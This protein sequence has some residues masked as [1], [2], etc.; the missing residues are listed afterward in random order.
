MSNGRLDTDELAVIPGGTKMGGSALIRADLLPGLVALQAA[1]RKRWGVPLRPTSAGDG[2][3]SYEVQRRTFLARYVPART[4]EGPFSDVR[5]WAG[6]RYVRISSAGSAAVPGT[7][8]HGDAVAVDFADVGP[9]GGERWRWLMDHAPRFGWTNPPWARD[10][11]P[12]NGSIE[13]WHWESVAVPVSQYLAYLDANGIEVPGL[14]A[15][16]SLAPVPQEDAMF[17]IS[18]PGRGSALVGPG[19]YRYL[20][21]VEEVD[22]ARGLVGAGNV[23]TGNDRQYD[24]WVSLIQ[25]GDP[26]ATLTADQH[27]WLENLYAAMFTGGV[28]TPEGKSLLALA[29]EGRNPATVVRDLDDDALAALA[30]QVA[31]LPRLVTDEQDRRARE[32]LA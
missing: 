20:N 29:A 21:S 26:S 6:T 14:T 3:R 25:T 27:R 8:N 24:L 32:R 23:R 5:W 28:S 30:G 18:S 13:P 4:G 10:D 19:Y 17:V 1:Y 9:R 11:N 31:D 12:R 7:S 15:P 22:A 16:D 2:Y